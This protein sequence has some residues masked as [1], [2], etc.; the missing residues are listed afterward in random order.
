MVYDNLLATY[1]EPVKKHE[2]FKPVKIFKTPTG[3]QVIDFGQNLV[4]WVA[5][6]VKGKCR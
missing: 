1:N 2:T 4:G 3:E 5:G 6:K